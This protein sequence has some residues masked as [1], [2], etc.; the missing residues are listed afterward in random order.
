MQRSRHVVRWGGGEG[1]R[2]TKNEGILMNLKQGI[3]DRDRTDTNYF[4]P[5]LHE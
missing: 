4:P 2:K 5:D 1:G 3:A